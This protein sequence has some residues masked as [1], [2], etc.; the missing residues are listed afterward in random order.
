MSFEK[1][2]FAL[3]SKHHGGRPTFA[4]TRCQTDEG[5]ALTLY[6]LLPEDI[7]EAREQRF[8]RAGTKISL[9]RVE[10]EDALVGTEKQASKG[11]ATLGV[12]TPQLNPEKWQWESWCAIEIK[13]LTG[14][15]LKAITGLVEN[16]LNEANI[17][18][19]TVTSGEEESVL[20]PEAVGVRLALAF[21]GMRPIQRYDRLRAFADGISKMSLEECYYWHAKSRSPTSPNGI[22]ALRVLLTDHIK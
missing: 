12:A 8:E 14:K 4:L 16:T 3:G 10:L 15:R 7:A 9:T 5:S 13:E 22:K 21:I 19:E 17:E 11:Q 18:A 6:E 1:E 2:S 20:L